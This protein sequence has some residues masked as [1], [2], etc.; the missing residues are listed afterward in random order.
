MY[1]ANK[2]KIDEDIYHNKMQKII[3]VTIH[4]RENWGS[5]IENVCDGL[6]KL[7]D[8]YLDIQIILPMHPNKIV[9]DTIIDNGVLIKFH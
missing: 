4:R 2:N 6:K 5:N 9:R 1:V 3:L 8:N 7:L